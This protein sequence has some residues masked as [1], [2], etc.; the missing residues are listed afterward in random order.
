MMKSKQK[1]FGYGILILVI[2]II[3]TSGW[4][5]SP[6][7]A[8]VEK[9]LEENSC[10]PSAIETNYGSEYFCAQYLRGHTTVLGGKIL[11]VPK[12]SFLFVFTPFHYYN[13]I[14]PET[15]DAHVYIF[16]ATRDEGT[17]IYNPVNGKYIGRFDDLLQEAD[18]SSQDKPVPH[19]TT[20]KTTAVVS[21]VIDGDTME[22]QTGER[23]RLLGI[24]TEE[25]GQKCYEEATE[26][27][28]EL[29]DGN[30][31]T[32]EKDVED[33]DQYDRLLRFVFIDGTN[34]NILLVREGLAT[35]YFVGQNTKYKTELEEAEE[36]AKQ[37]GGC[38]WAAPSDDPCA[39]CI[40][41]SYF[42][43]NAKGND[44]DNL[45]DEYVTFKN[46]CTF[47]CDITSWT[48]KDE[49]SRDPYVFPDFALE[50][51]AIVTLY[52]GCGTNTKTHVYW[53]S[54]G[55]SCNAIWNNNG[56]TLYLR[57]QNSELVLSY[58]YPE[59]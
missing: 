55:R 30:E 56:D 57:N 38:I 39:Y 2:S 29:I 15:F 33:K 25:K 27:L 7:K 47:S 18:T 37:E 41:I 9:F 44:C 19:S 24:N 46:T 11:K 21:K 40:G 4:F 28:K 52:T 12:F 13:H 48:V 14:E 50:S 26:R 16:V 17:L 43:W 36:L 5:I 51:G 53:C 58:S 45:K 23:V 8:T 1:Y 22:L 34:V 54:S 42:H 35:T 10:N 32:L 59:Y 20:E 3:L 31:V 49:S 6:T